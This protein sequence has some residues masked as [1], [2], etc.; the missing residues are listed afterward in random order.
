MAETT[1]IEDEIK[2]LIVERLFL[3]IDPSEI[4]DD[5]VL[6]EKL[7][8]DSIKLLEIVVG[9]QEAYEFEIG[10]DEFSPDR[11]E[12]VAAIADFVR[13]KTGHS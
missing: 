6:M 5:D 1:R 7:D 4:A 12:T 8:V 2:A 11:F 3:D 13:E 10:D 9:I